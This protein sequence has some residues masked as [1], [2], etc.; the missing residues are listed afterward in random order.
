MASPAMMGIGLGLTG[1]GF[2]TALTG[3]AIYVAQDKDNCI[4]CVE[5]QQH[6]AAVVAAGVVGC[7]LGLTLMFL[8]GRQVP[9]PAWAKAMP[10]LVAVGPRGGVVGWNF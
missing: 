6:A 7:G 1:I 2:L 8:G 10:S 5:K 3:G 9:A 4:A